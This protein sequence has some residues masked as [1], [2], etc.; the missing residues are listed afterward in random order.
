MRIS[1]DK[2]QLR[3]HAWQTVGLFGGFTLVLLVITF[4]QMKV[5][6]R[7]LIRPIA[8]LVDAAE[9]ARTQG[10][11][12]WHAPATTTDEVARLGRSMQAMMAAVF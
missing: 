11:Y 2:A 4:G 7:T 6:Q 10:D 8:T 12:S 9:L 1:I 3:Q 5:L